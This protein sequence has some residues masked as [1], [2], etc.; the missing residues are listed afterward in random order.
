MASDRA[1]RRVRRE[2][3]IMMECS[4]PYLP[5]FG[6]LPLRELMLPSGEKVVYFLEEYI[7]GF[8]L[9]SV[10]TPMPSQ[11]VVW[12]A[13]CIAEALRVLASHGY[14]HRDVKPMNIMQRTSSTYVL[15]DA[16][17]ALDLDGELISLAGAPPV[18]TKAYYSPE[19][20]TLSSRE[21]DQRS[22][23]FSLGVTMY[24]C[25]AGEHPF[26][27]DELPRVDVSRNIVELSAPDP[28]R[29]VRDLP[30]GLCRVI[31]KLLE[32]DR[33]QRY[34]SP[35]ALLADLVTVDSVVPLLRRFGR[36][37]PSLHGPCW[38]SKIHRNKTSVPT[39]CCN[40]EHCLESNVE[41]NGPYSQT[42]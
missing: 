40:V 41:A 34:V 37:R 14:V 10:H 35:D 4:S 13:R 21:L 18:G 2:I 5:K 9:A 23:L 15:I 16:G 22:D 27:N 25:A 26:L 38:A 17:L 36:G 28:Q 11:Q 19:Q 31:S 3:G 42:G 7:D 20:V 29:F 6:P 33:A 30:S 12:L 24:E 39:A 1:L 32:K 8:P